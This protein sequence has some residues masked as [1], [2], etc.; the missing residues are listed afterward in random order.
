[1]TDFSLSSVE[2]TPKSEPQTTVI[3]LHGLGADGYDFEPLA[4]ELMLPSHLAVRFVFPHAPERPVTINGGMRM[5]AWYDFLSLDF[6][7][8]EN[9][10]DIEASVAAVTALLDAE[11]RRGVSPE[12]MV[13]GG[14]SQGG[15]IALHTALRYPHR[16]AGLAGLSTYLPLT[17]TLESAL[18]PAQRKTPILLAH[19]HQDP[20]I[21]FAE[22]VRA[23]EWLET[24]GYPVSFHE[25]DMPHSV[26]E[27]EIRDLRLWLLSILPDG[28]EG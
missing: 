20:I 9:N 23:R 28:E 13:L 21:P 15:V 25:Y 18:D 19:G 8:G 17:G 7:K 4:R 24:A 11:M 16:L 14:F 5:R 27:A 12:R 1:M 3:W 2:I 10:R 22:G 6:G 26:C